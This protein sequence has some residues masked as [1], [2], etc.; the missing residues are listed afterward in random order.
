VAVGVRGRYLSDHSWK[1]IDDVVIGFDRRAKAIVTQDAPS[2][3]RGEAENPRDDE[4][5]ILSTTAHRNDASPRSPRLDD[6]ATGHAA[7][8]G[9]SRSSS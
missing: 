3:D 5:A 1:P 6:F 4:D 8:G 2:V 9:F 7:G